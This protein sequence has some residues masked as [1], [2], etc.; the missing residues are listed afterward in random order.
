MSLINLLL[1]LFTFL[2]LGALIFLFCLRLRAARNLSKEEMYKGIAE[3]E[4]FF[5]DFKILIEKQNLDKMK[6]IFLRFC[7]ACGSALH[8]IK[9]RARVFSNRLNGKK[10]INSNGCSGYW[11]ELNETKDD[12]TP[13]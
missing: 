8:K 6:R 4:P 7:P 13:R 12:E 2:S 9:C 11:K 1:I 10:D 3:A 5:A